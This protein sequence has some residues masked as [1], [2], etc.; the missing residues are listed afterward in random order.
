VFVTVIALAGTGLTVL[1]S[2]AQRWATS[3]DNDNVAA[4]YAGVILILSI[5]STI[6]FLWLLP[7]R[8]EQYG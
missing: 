3:I 4:A 5:V 6:L 8:E 1:A 2:Q 7:T